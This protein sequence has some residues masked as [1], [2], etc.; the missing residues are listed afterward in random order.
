MLNQYKIVLMDFKR[1]TLPRGR[2]LVEEAKT[3]A[4]FFKYTTHA[5]FLIQLRGKLYTYIQR[6]VLA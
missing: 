6:L 3:R 2:K 1:R 4:H 5:T